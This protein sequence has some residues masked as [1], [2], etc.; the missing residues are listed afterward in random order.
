MDIGYKNEWIASISDREII[1][2]E[3]ATVLV[4]DQSKDLRLTVTKT[5][6]LFPGGFGRRDYVVVTP[7][8]GWD[9]PKANRLLECLLSNRCNDLGNPAMGFI[10]DVRGG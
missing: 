5:T 7:T 10:V 8:V 1:V 3:T 6:K 4:F 9:G 2:N